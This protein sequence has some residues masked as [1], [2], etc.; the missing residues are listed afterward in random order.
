[1]GYNTWVSGIYSN[2]D[3]FEVF[4]ELQQE[5]CAL[6]VIISENLGNKHLYDSE[7]NYIVK[8]SKHSFPNKIQRLETEN[9]K[10]RECVEFYA[11][12]E[13]WLSGHYICDIKED[14]SNCYVVF[15]GIQI[16]SQTLE[17]IN[18]DTE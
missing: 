1:M 11:E 4:E 16:A 6:R 7:G 15:K 13:R 18:N 3:W 9:K 5:C 2:E 17:D 10:L 12:K 14:G 8:S